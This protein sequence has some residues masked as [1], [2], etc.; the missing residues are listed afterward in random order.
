MKCAF[1]FY[2]SLIS[3]FCFGQYTHKNFN[4]DLEFLYENLKESASYKA[5]RD[6]HNTIVSK[7]EEL[8]RAVMTP[9]VLDSYIKLYYCKIHSLS[10]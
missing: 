4:N 10:R 5:Q 2:L 3:I 1:S 7:Y 8:K 6:R 9:N